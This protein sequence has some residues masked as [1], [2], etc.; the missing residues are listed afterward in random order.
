L[1]VKL[2]TQCT[3]KAKL[4][5]IVVGF[6]GVMLSMSALY[7]IQPH[8]INRLESGEFIPQRQSSAPSLQMADRRN[9]VSP[10][11]VTKRC[12]RYDYHVFENRL[13]ELLTVVKALNQPNNKLVMVNGPQ[14]CGKTSL[15]RGVIEMMGGGEEQVLWFDVH[16]H[17]DTD[18]VIRFLLHLL[19]D[20]CQALRPGL[21]Q[22]APAQDAAQVMDPFEQLDR[23]LSQMTDIPLL[24]VMDN[25]EYLVTDD[26][27]LRGQPLK[28]M[29]NF[30]LSFSNIRLVLCGEKLPYSDMNPN[31]P[32]VCHLVLKGLSKTDLVELLSEKSV[33]P[34]VAEA[35]LTL[36]PDTL[37][38]P[39]LLKILLFLVQEGEASAIIELNAQ[40]QQKKADRGLQ[41]STDLVQGLMRHL[42]AL[43]WRQLPSEDQAIG[44]LMAVIRHPINCPALAALAQQV[45][46]PP[47]SQMNSQ[48]VKEVLSDT[49]LL[50]LMKR[51]YPP[52]DVLHHIQRRLEPPSTFQ[53]GYEFYRS[54][55]TAL[56]QHIP[57][58]DR[59]YL[60]AGAARFYIAQRNL[61]VAQRLVA[62]KTRFLTDEAQYH[63]HHTRTRRGM[64]G[65][66]LLGQT[67]ESVV[68]RF[69]TPQSIAY[70]LGVIQPDMAETAANNRLKIESLPVETVD[71]R[72]DTLPGTPSG[73][74]IVPAII[75]PTVIPSS[76]PSSMQR[77]GP[78]KVS[79]PMV[80][81]DMLTLSD[82]EKA[83][84]AE[85][86]ALSDTDSAAWYAALSSGAALTDAPSIPA[87]ANMP[88]SEVA[89]TQSLHIEPVM[90]EGNGA[91]PPT[92]ASTEWDRYLASVEEAPSPLARIQKELAQAT[93]EQ[94]K[95]A[96]VQ[97][98]NALAQYHLSERTY[99][100]AEDCYR[101]IIALAQED[102]TLADFAVDARLDLG[103][104]YEARLHLDKAQQLYQAVKQSL[105]TAKASQTVLGQRARVCRYL[106]DLADVDGNH[107]QSIG[108][109]QEAIVSLKQQSPQ[110]KARLGEAHFKL[111]QAYDQHRQS[112]A[113]VGH[114]LQSL[115]FEKA[116]QHWLACAAVLT[117]LGTIYTENGMFTEAI[118]ALTEAFAYDG[119][120]QNTEGQLYTLDLLAK[121][122]DEQGN[123][124][125]VVHT[126][127]Q[128]L[129]LAVSTDQNYWKSS[130]YL[131]LGYAAQHQGDL[132]K[133]LDYFESARDAARHADLADE[134]LIY[135][136]QLVEDT[137]HALRP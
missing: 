55:K 96:M 65:P 107:A 102:A 28:D 34:G 13:E 17:T 3:I 85:S 46:Q 91:E 5:A 86:P 40:W 112:E 126:Y 93:A 61:P 118:A 80:D 27:T 31:A 7:F 109:Y 104:V 101:K 20:V 39:W 136:N 121:I 52:Q 58:K 60:H 4:V 116:N 8:I 47:F 33:A 68:N 38:E 41:A 132:D 114:Y 29:L 100:Q 120:V 24:L 42:M 115:H 129:T 122:Y 113:A 89:S 123:T 124:D 72:E 45:D 10:L 92:T 73:A 26:Q 19:L 35:I 90:P 43:I 133:A 71:D 1:P 67:A 77:H 25:L 134:S 106:G 23:L 128:A 11:A 2:P 54:V 131:K 37:G 130:V 82:A 44:K 137:Q 87:V 99:T 56:V 50:P 48:S 111:G 88:A 49:W 74:S 63:E 94:N 83:L 15:I 22:Q 75:Q 119:Q 12:I 135:L 30:L 18:E 97:Q 21:A 14:G 32:S 57:S 6:A 64:E 95:P 98:L 78:P 125:A 51:M 62:S 69:K 110:D 9:V 84:I 103:Q 70:Q 76:L 66:A 108:L 79:S 16:P 127:K 117:N 59:Q 36:Y 53:P 81:V 105:D